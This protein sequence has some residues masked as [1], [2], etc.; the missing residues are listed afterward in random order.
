[1]DRQWR[2]CQVSDFSQ[3]SSQV[4]TRRT[5]ENLTSNLFVKILYSQM[6]LKSLKKNKPNLRKLGLMI[7]DLEKSAID[8]ID[9]EN[10]NF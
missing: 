7:Y 5:K 2:T 6:T 3:R 9:V 1:M 8:V 4:K 10:A